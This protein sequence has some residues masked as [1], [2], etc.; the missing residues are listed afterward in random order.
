MSKT[1]KTIYEIGYNLIPTISEEEVAKQVGA[2]KEKITSLGGIIISDEY[3]NL[4][5]LAYE[6]TKEIENK[7]VRFTSAYFGWVKFELDPSMIAE[8]NKMADN[9]LSV[10][11]YIV[12]KTVREN[13][14][15]TPKLVKGNRRSSSEESSSSESSEAPMDEEAVD[16]KI[17]EL[18]EEDAAL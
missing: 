3:P 18:I 2:I 1:D 4:I 6:M 11:R 14:I 5:K 9:T 8:I 13:T 10:L 17:D 12:I 16:K 15:S 7:N